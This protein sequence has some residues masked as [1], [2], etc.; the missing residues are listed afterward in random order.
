MVHCVDLW[1]DSTDWHGLEISGS[2]HLW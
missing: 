1:S 2:G